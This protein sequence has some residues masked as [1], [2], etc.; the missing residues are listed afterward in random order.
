MVL[1]INDDAAVLDE[2]GQH[3]TLVTT[4]AFVEGV[5][6][7]RAYATCR[8]IGW[9]AMA[10]G[11]SDIAAM[12]GRP[13]AATVALAVSQSESVQDIESLYD[14]MDALGS[15]FGCDI[16]GGD[17][18]S[19]GGPMMLSLTVL[20]RVPRD[21]LARRSGARIGDLICVTGPLGMSAAGLMVLRTR[22]DAPRTPDEAE[23]IAAH[24]EP[25]PCLPEAAFLAERGIVSAMIDISDGLSSDLHHLCTQSRVGACVLEARIPLTDATER[26]AGSLGSTPTDLALSGGEDFQ[27]LFTVSPRDAEQCAAESRF[28]AIGEIV[29]QASGVTLRRKDGRVEDLPFTGYQHFAE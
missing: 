14:G 3:L 18:V 16:V 4:D 1:G 21:R 8:Q 28:T 13:T 23:V 2:G 17:T 29:A 25:R 5:H 19:S 22:P 24:L 11:L 27:L 10:A 6:F 7:D 15:R 12:A 26:I 9:K 20:G